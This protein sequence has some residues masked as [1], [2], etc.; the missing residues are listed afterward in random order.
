MLPTTGSWLI[1]F[2][3]PLTLHG[4]GSGG[5]RFRWP[6]ALRRKETRSG[7]L[8]GL[9]FFW[10]SKRAFSVPLYYILPGLGDAGDRYFGT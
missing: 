2:P 7:F 4:D 1:V 9:L 10:A 3:R 8:Y 6:R 5:L